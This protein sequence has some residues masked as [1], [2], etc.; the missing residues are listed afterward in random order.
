MNSTSVLNNLTIVE[1]HI[2]REA[3]RRGQSH[4]ALYR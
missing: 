3:T 2:A 4:R 1:Q